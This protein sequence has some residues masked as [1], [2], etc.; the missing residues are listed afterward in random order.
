MDM[1]ITLIGMPASGKSTLGKS[2]AKKLNY[3]F[4]DLDSLIVKL[5]NKPIAEIFAEN[6]EAYFRQVEREALQ[7]ALNQPNTILATGGGAPC[8]FDNMDLINQ[9]SLS[10]YLKTELPI[11]AQ[12]IQNDRRNTRPLYQ[13]ESEEDLLPKLKNTWNNRHQFYEKAK[14]HWLLTA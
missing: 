11:L 13:A 10:I 4:L 9:K 2:L 5:Q 7:M 1:L 14:I 6:G 12:R 3:Q 8:F